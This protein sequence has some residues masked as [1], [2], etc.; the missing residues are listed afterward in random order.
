[1][2]K[3]LTGFTLIEL[4]VVLF[5][6][7]LLMVGLL[8]S[9]GTHIKSQKRQQAVDT[10][11]D[12]MESLYGY[13]IINKHLPC[14]DTTGDGASNLEGSGTCTATSGA[15]WLPWKT[16]GLGMQG[17]AWGNRFKYHVTTPGFTTM[18]NGTCE[19]DDNLDLCEFGSIT[20]YTR[21]DNPGTRIIESKFKSEAATEVPAVVISHGN[22]S[23]GATTVAGV[24]L[25]VAA[26]GTDEYE[27][28]D[29]DTNTTFYSRTFS[30][31]GDGCR[32]DANESNFLCEF[33]DIVMWV[34]HPILMNRLVKAEVLP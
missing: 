6:I 1:M 12:I 8:G 18:D 23:L 30:N 33:D 22:N 32:D 15:G 9:V 26:A 25:A 5:I 29:T 11:H 7:S 10:M 24:K 14:P 31:G 19:K 27:N 28:A 4:S 17:D 34:S 16:L 20:I 3:K 2:C 21:G 13:A